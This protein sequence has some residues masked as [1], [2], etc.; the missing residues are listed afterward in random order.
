MRDD[1]GTPTRDERDEQP[2]TRKPYEPPV[3]EDI[4]TTHG[5]AETAP[6]QSQPR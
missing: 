3:A 1:S 6:G 4:D 2:M 5:P